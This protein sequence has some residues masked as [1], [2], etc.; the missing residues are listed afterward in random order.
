MIQILNEAIVLVKKKI[1]TDLRRRELVF[2]GVIRWKIIEAAFG[3]GKILVCV[4][5]VCLSAEER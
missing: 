4:K 1:A 3:S 5:R 2:D